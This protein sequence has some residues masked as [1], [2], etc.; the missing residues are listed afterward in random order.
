MRKPTYGPNSVYQ[1]LPPI[2]AKKARAIA[3]DSGTVRDVGD[4]HGVSRMTV[5]RIRTGKHV[6]TRRGGG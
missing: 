4:R 5:S 3:R 1:G 2:S 6:S